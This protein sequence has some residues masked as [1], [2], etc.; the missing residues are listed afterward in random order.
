MLRITEK[1]L[2]LGVGGGYDIYTALPWFLSLSDQEQHQCLLANYSF[3]DD[4]YKYA[5]TEKQYIIEVSP[6]TVRTEKNRNYFPE[7]HLATSLNRTIYAVRLVPCPLLT[8][9]LQEFIEE[10]QIKRLLLFDGGTDSIIFGDEGQIYGSPLEDSQTILAAYHSGLPCI[11]ITSALGIDDCN[12][13]L[14][15][16]RAEE[17][18]IHNFKVGPTLTGWEDY[19]RIVQ[20]SV[21][22]SIIQESILAA[23][24]GH[25]GIYVNPRLFPERISKE[26][27]LPKI[28]EGTNRFSLWELDQLVERSP[29]YQRLL[30]FD[31]TSKNDLIAIWIEWNR[32]LSG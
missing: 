27:D 6:S 30:G 16:K 31:P 23:G 18:T 21:P 4:L 11:L 3:T 1:T 10:H 5:S 29:F 7:H 17:M 8:T 28:L 14:Y 22:P 26:E 19:R 15:L 2:V 20:S 12:V 25:R 9:V 13:D 32:I 24:D